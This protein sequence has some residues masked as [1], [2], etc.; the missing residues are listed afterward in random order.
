MGPDGE[1]EVEERFVILYLKLW[2]M[3]RENG[4]SYFAEGKYDLAVASYSDAIVRDM[5]T[6]LCL[7]VWQL[8]IYTD[9]V[10]LIIMNNIFIGFKS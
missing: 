7:F 2:M 8:L 10:V 3:S 6:R 9:I 5:A 4:N 1:E